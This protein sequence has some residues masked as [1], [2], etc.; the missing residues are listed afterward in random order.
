MGSWSADLCFD[1]LTYFTSGVN[2]L[3][4]ISQ[5]GR[6]MM[7]MYFIFWIAEMCLLCAVVFQDVG[8]DSCCQPVARWVRGHI[9]GGD[10]D[11]HQTPVN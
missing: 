4:V 6:K 9:D 8:H 11:S 2:A 5:P 1:S 7:I 10:L 3:S